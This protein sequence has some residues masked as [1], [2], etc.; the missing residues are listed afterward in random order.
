[1]NPLLFSIDLEEY[2]L[3]RGGVDPRSAPL[4]ELAERYLELL[5]KANARCTF[6]VVGEV[7]RKYPGLIRRIAGAGHEIACHGDRHVSLDKLDPET[8]ARDLR[9]NRSALEAAGAPPARGFRAPLF[10]LT[11]STSWAHSVLLAEGFTYSSSVL[12]A[13]N[14]LF[15]WPEFGTRPR[16]VDGITELPVTVRTFLGRRL[17]LFGGTYFR[18]LPFA[19][20]RPRLR[21]SLRAGHVVSYFHPYDIDAGQPWTLHAGVRGNRALNS[22]LF[23]RRR[24]LPARL[25]LLLGEADRHLSHAEF[26]SEARLQPFQRQPK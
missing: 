6:F 18:V 19:V 5:S 13:A 1:M 3:E 15:G 16:V 20:V 4:P 23:L 12:P 21:S 2:Y 17:P 14:P 22:L 24:S 11:R 8:F 7:A 26:I 25:G 9:A 10:S